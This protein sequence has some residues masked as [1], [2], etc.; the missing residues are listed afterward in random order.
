MSRSNISRNFFYIFTAAVVIA[1]T[2]A[3]FLPT[4]T[5]DNKST[6]KVTKKASKKTKPAVIDTSDDPKAPLEEWSRVDINVYLSKRYITPS[7]ESTDEELKALIA[8]LQKIAA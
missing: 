8:Q 3:L 6:P 1:G 4:A 5:L 2:A 7:D